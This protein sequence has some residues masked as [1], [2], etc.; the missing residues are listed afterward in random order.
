M[1]SFDYLIVGA[2]FA[3]AVCAERLAAAGRQVLVI[4]RRAYVGGNAHD[5]FNDAGILCGK[6]GAHVFH[7]NSRRVLDYL[8]QFTEWRSYEHRVLS[9][10][11]GQLLP[12]PINQTTLEA[13]G[14]DLVAAEKAMIEPYT[15]KQWGEY[16]DQLSP[17]VLARIKT[18]ETRDD[19]Y[20]TDTY[21]AMPLHGYTRLFER[22]LD[23]PNITVQI[24]T[25]YE[26]LAAKGHTYGA[27][28][29][30]GPIDAFF[31]HC[32]GALPYRSATFIFATFDHGPYQAVGVVNHPSERVPFTRS[33]EFKH[34]TGQ[35][36]RD[37]TVAHEYPT[38]EGEPF[39]PI[40]TAANLERYRQYQALARERRDVYF[41]G[42]L[43]TYKYIDMDIAVAQA[44]ALT[45][46]LV[47]GQ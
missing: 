40:P 36:H 38:A 41:V 27:I 2:G 22:I 34:I 30:S 32:L 46:R 9:S 37:T 43:G 33:I 28:I 13:F 23:H 35:V 3:G 44:L 21:Q 26:A 5:E 14:G 39:W 25:P 15:R 19:R 45:R 42:R 29:W 10:V 7:T 8:S 16:A 1:P 6:H 12:V 31:N 20:F 24:E 47:G 11:N 4:D 18:R 17:I